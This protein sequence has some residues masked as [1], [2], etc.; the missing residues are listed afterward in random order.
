[1]QLYMFPIDEEPK[2][3]L[4]KR[5]WSRRVA[6]LLDDDLPLFYRRKRGDK[7]TPEEQELVTKYLPLIK[8]T[9]RRAEQRGIVLDD[10]EGELVAYTCH[11]MP[12]FDPTRASLGSLLRVA[13][14]NK[15]KNMCRDASRRIRARNDHQE[16]LDKVPDQRRSGVDEVDDADEVCGEFLAGLPRGY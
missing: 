12:R 16:S 15:I 2:K 9:A 3:F 13:L 5:R 1:M 7:L 11:V 4:A 14:S 10:L 6:K 8:A